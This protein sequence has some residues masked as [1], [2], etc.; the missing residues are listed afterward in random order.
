M[1]FELK[2]SQLN[3]L[4]ASAL[5]LGLQ[6][7]VL[8][9]VP[10]PEEHAAA[11]QQIE[12]AIQAA[13]TEARSAEACDY[14]ISTEWG[15]DLELLNQLHF[16]C[17]PALLQC[18]GRN[19][20]RRDTIHPSESQWFDWRT[21]SSSQYPAE[22][23]DSLSL[24]HWGWPFFVCVCVFCVTLKW[25]FHLH[26]VKHNSV[27]VYIPSCIHHPTTIWLILLNDPLIH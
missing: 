18:S 9:A 20:K 2:N 15:C 13:V 17:C 21:V 11:G 16:L 25:V 24:V 26:I 3:C 6:G 12:E 22:I 27:V 19:R 7:G 10:V 1:L 23:S 8:L 5:S 14:Q 4:L